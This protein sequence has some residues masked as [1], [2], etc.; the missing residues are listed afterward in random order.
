MPFSVCFPRL[1]PL[2]NALF[3]SQPFSRAPND[4]QTTDH[5]RNGAI[6][7]QP[8]NEAGPRD[9]DKDHWQTALS[10][11]PLW[12]FCVAALGLTASAFYVVTLRLRLAIDLERYLEWK[13][14]LQITVC[15]LFPPLTGSMFLVVTFHGI[16]YLRK[17][18]YFR[19][20]SK[21][22]EERKSPSMFVKIIML[23]GLAF[24]VFAVL[25]NLLV[26]A[27]FVDLWLVA[28]LFIVYGA[29]SLSYW[30]LNVDAKGEW[31]R[32]VPPIW[33]AVRTIPAL[34]VCAF[35]LGF[36][37]DSRVLAHRSVSTIYLAGA[38]SEVIHGRVLF[39]MT[40]YLMAF[41]EGDNAFVA[42]PS[43]QVLRVVTPPL[44]PLAGKLAGSPSPGL[45]P[46]AAATPPTTPATSPLVPA[47]P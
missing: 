27:I 3:M 43:G 39:G 20:K 32:N 37:L 28:G 22:G 21:L 24:S 44:P 33:R 8:G 7:D 23:A 30:L 26:I 34:Y 45:S 16:K 42:I 15:W 9:R 47:K 40:K 10:N 46:S 1:R 5:A 19:L 31:L 17:K 14:Y 12:I 13:D 38:N 35:T 41:R 18:G 25:F 6:V 2:A 36:F 4:Q 11:A 29:T